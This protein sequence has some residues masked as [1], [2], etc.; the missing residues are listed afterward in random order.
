[1]TDSPSPS[2]QADNK[3]AG[4]AAEKAEP[5]HAAAN[6]PVAQVKKPA[7]AVEDTN[8][9]KHFDQHRFPPGYDY[10]SYYANYG[11][12]GYPPPGYGPPGQLLL[13]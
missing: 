6:A 1:M 10:H 12:G 13:L 7:A 4:T 11:Y 9:A 2:D 3:A 5:Q 8:G